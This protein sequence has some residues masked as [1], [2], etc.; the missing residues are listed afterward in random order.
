MRKGGKGRESPFFLLIVR[1]LDVGLS[2]LADWMFPLIH[3]CSSN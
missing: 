2:F 1:I 3:Y